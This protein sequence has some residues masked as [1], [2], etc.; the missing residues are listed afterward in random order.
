MS[1]AT[2]RK[3]VNPIKEQNPSTVF[4]EHV[5]KNLG[6]H[7]ALV[8]EYEYEHKEKPTPCWKKDMNIPQWLLITLVSLGIVVFTAFA[9]FAAVVTLKKETNG[10][11]CTSNSDCR[12]DL[13]LMCNNYR[14]GCAYSHFW[15]DTY[16]VCE[17]RR[18]INRTCVNDSM[19]DALGNLQCSNVT[20][21]SGAI[22]LQCQCQSAM[23]WN[24][25][26]CAYQGLYN[27]SCTQDSNCDT[28]R[29]LYC[30]FVVGGYCRCNT[31]M[32]WNGN[33]NSGTCEYKRTVNQYCYP[34]NDNWCDDTG[35]VGQ[36]LTCASYTNPYGSEY[37]V[38]QC[39]TNEYYNG[40]ASLAN[41]FCVAQHVYNQSCTSTSQCDYR[42]NLTCSNNL[43]T[44]SSGYNYDSSI[45]SSGVM[46]YCKK[47]S[48]YLEN[49]TVVLTCSTSQNLYCDLSYYGGL[50]T[51]G[52]CQCNSS[53]SYWDGTTCASKLSIGGL[54]SSNTNCISSEGLFCSNYT[55]SI[56]T[57]DCDSSHY[58]NNTCSLKLWYN[59]SC[60]SS[61]VCDDNRGL[62]CQGLGGSMFQKCDC[63]NTSYIWDSLYTTRSNK[64][65]LKLGYNQSTCYGNLEC[66]DYNYLVCNGTKCACLYTAYWDGS[67]C[68]P[69]RNYTDPCSFT[70][71]CR[72][73]G[74]V[75]LIC[76]M[77]T[78]V[79]P[80]LQCLCNATS[81][82]DDCQQACIVSKKIYQSCTLTANC[83]SNECD[84]TA[85]LQC[86]N[87]SLTS[88][89]WCNCTSLQW[90]NGSYCRDKGI[91]AWGSNSSALCN[92]SYQCADYNLVSCPLGARWPSLNSTCECATTK[93][94]NGVTCLDRVTN[95]Q[96][97]T[98]W[99]TS[100]VNTSTCLSAAGAGLIC[101]S[102]TCVAGTCT[103]GTC[104]C[105]TG[106]TWNS[107]FAICVAPSSG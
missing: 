87:G 62:Q 11:P 100:P 92:S 60:T 44:C 25:Y 27:A 49:C 80:T 22:Q 76:I 7:N 98:L 42:I 14:C 104:S 1:R 90:W 97:C 79:P 9:L 26:A 77:G 107:S 6:A 21:S 34:Y 52:V 68:Q 46:G 30:N 17:R 83:S 78:S 3:A 65:I 48:G 95:G 81:F 61:Y 101:S 102:S 99:N 33:M 69:K 94:W 12:Q 74:P 53:W 51:T 31:S 18:M 50:N 29:Y 105:P 93:Y 32:F 63:Y 36:G 82:W 35:P 55:Q 88:S 47:A 24:G 67:V 56:G 16:Q 41:G 40:S 85:N 37:G 106:Y 4:Q 28:T 20:L 84:K 19:C 96:S 2:K 59:S 57:C 89:G 72:D 58:W 73:F 86:L 71:Q 54:C 10:G 43:C 91:P 5:V 75:N 70:Y 39:E 38:C 66:Q 23:S 103:G 64:C 8:S 15:S 13:G 45:N